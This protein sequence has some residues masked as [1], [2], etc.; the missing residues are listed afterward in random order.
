MSYK[1]LVK[2]TH[3]EHNAY[4]PYAAKVS[5]IWTKNTARRAACFKLSR[6]I[7]VDVHVGAYIGSVTERHGM[8]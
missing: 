2:I 4:N 8:C 5:A 6:G 7:P 1:G 3:F